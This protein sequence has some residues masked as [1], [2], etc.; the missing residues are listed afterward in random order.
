MKKMMLLVFAI[1]LLAGS[2]SAADSAKNLQKI[3]PVD[4]E[5]YKAITYLYLNQGYS[6]PS[7]TGPWSGDELLKMLD[8]INP[9]RLAPGAAETYN[10]ALAELSQKRKAVKLNLKTS[11]EGYYHTN[12]TDFTKESQWIRGFDERSP[13]LDIILETW[14]SEHFYGYSSL[15]VQNSRFNDWSSTEGATSTLWGSSALT[16]NIPLVAPAVIDDL[17]FNVPYRAFGSIGGDGWSAEIGRDKYSWGP[18]ESGNFVLGS[19]FLYHNMGRLTTYGKNF[20]YTFA[21]SFF[22]HPD[23]YYPVIDGAGNYINKSGQ[24]DTVD[25]LYMF[26]GHRL[27]GRMFSDKVGFTLTEAIMYE[28]LDNKIDLTVLSPTAIFHNYYIRNNANSIISLEADYT[29]FKI[30]NLYGQMVVDEFCLPGEP[31]PGED[32][33]ALPSAYGF[34]LGAKASQPIGKGML[35]GSAEWAKTDPYLYIRDNGSRN[36][37]QGDYGLGWI[38]AT[39]EFANGLGISYT[40]DYLGYQYGCDAIVYNANLGYKVF[41]KWSLVGNAFY[42]IHGTHDQWTTWGKQDD[43]AQDTETTPTTTH[44]TANNADLNADERDAASYTFVV[45]ARGSYTILRG[46]DLYGQVD[47]IHITNPGNISTNEPISDVQ[48]TAGVKY[49]F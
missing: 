31:V 19:H 35:F 37:K 42:M 1:C 9:A 14:P 49:S 10:Y 25:G 34:M 12:T 45:G 48:V 24:D 17:D 28:S 46:L 6:L 40:E 16:T 22:P 23:N 36:Q 2:V 39:R 33:S 41:G 3:Y 8:R 29:P 38:A 43:S 15:P 26:I 5:I 18:G 27:E 30:V 7:T 47:Y 32:A 44:S 11:L 4:S 21:T 20:K 13:I